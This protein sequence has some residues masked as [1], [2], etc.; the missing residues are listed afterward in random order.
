MDEEQVGLNGL[1]W[2]D[3]A[4]ITLICAIVLVLIFGCKAPPAPAAAS[5]VEPAVS[6]PVTAE[7]RGDVT[8]ELATIQKTLSRIENTQQ[9]QRV[10]MADKIEGVESLVQQAS[11]TMYG[12]SPA[13]AEIEKQRLKDQNSERVTV[14]GVMTGLVLIALATAAIGGPVLLIVGIVIVAVALLAPVL[15]PLIL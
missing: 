6:T 10:E 13:Q 14:V 11:T 7:A 15:L 3:W 8:Q 12:L 2:A 9:S 1:S 5:H 4:I